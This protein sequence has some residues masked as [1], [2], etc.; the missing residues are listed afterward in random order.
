M[1]LTDKSYYQLLLV[2]CTSVLVFNSYELTFVV[3]AIAALITTRKAY[4]VKIIKLLCIPAGIIAIALFSSLFS[5]YRLYNF[6]RDLAYL[7]KPVLGLLI[8]YNLCKILGKQMLIWLIYAGVLLAAVHLLTLLYYYVL[9]GIR[10]MNTLRLYGGYFNDL[11]VY[12]LIMLLFRKKLD[13]SINRTHFLI[14]TGLVA[15]S[16]FLYLA[17]TNIIQFIILWLAMKGHLR[18]TARSLKVLGFAT[19]C[20]LI[21][22]AVIYNSNPKREGP[23]LEGF[24]YKIKIAPIEAFKT[25]IDKEDWKDWN[26]NYRSYENNI[27]VRQMTNDGWFTMLFGKG[28]GSTVDL[29]RKLWTNDLEFIRH[30]PTLHNAYMT[31]FLKAGI[32]GILLHLLFIYFLCRN[33][34]TSDEHVRTLNF[35][36]LGSA[37][38]LILSNWVFMGLYLKLDNKSIVL[39]VLVAYREILIRRKPQQIVSR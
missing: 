29:G 13:I 19:I 38:Y 1:Q 36:L 9:I 33:P 5:E 30:L 7:S 10:D 14:F 16:L 26:D 20:V 12:V 3:W 24:F 18:P 21:G 6:L 11:E 4:S 27:T 25:K 8:G 35:L 39:G 32:L 37:I 34:K 28:M 15:L 23:G 2:V 31:V 17:R 22:Y